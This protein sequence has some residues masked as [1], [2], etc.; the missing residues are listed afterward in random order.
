MNENLTVIK[1]DRRKEQ[2]RQQLVVALLQQPSI[3]KAAKSVGISPVT[4]WRISKTPEF[5]QE[6]GRVRRD[7]Y[8]QSQAR[9]QQ[10]SS[11]A[12]STLLKIM[13]D[14]KTPAA[15]RLRATEC[16][17][18]HAAES[19]EAEELA[20]RVQSIEQWMKQMIK[21]QENTKGNEQPPV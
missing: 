1:T 17:L 3:E 19:F 21:E 13:E 12:A 4:A 15:V 11:A 8:E 16:V 20:T 14:P 18:Q 5:Q 2:Q 10:A 7:N 9:L 6:Y